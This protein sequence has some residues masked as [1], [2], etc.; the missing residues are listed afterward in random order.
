MLCRKCQI[1]KELSE[2]HKDEHSKN[3]HRNICKACVSADNKK[4]WGIKKAKKANQAR[5]KE[6]GSFDSLCFREWAARELP[7]IPVISIYQAV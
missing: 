6:L 7:V 2:F 1:D 5:V 3:G 4:F